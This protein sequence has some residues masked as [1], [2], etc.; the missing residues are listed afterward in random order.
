MKTRKTSVR[1]LLLG[2][3]VLGAAVAPGCMGGDAAQTNLEYLPEM[4]DSV[5]FDS[6]SPNPNTHDGKTLMAPPKGAIPRGFVPLHFGP[7]PEEAARA[8][9][10]L[11]NPL[12]DA[13]E[14]TARGQA[15]FKRFCTPCHGAAGAGDGPIVPPFPAPPPLTADH[16]KKMPDGQMFHVIG[17]GQGL[18]PAHGAQI[19]QQ[20]RWALVRFLRTLQGGGAGGKQ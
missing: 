18:M 13:P 2:T 19:A 8:G 20:D 7:G 16:A 11:Q 6:F 1:T 14:H 4:I 17:Y 5:P 15:L 12:P 9:R 3:A 10:E